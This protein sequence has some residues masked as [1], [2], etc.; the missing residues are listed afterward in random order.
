MRACTAATARPVE[1]RPGSEPVPGYRLVARVIDFHNEPRHQLEGRSGVAIHHRDIKPQN[2][3]L[4]GQGVKVADLGLSCLDQ[5]GGSARSQCGLAFAYAAPETFR[6]RVSTGS[7]QY[8]LAITFC[9]L[10]SGPPPS[11]CPPPS[12]ASAGPGPA[13]H[14]LTGDPPSR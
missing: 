9:Q 11:P 1:D 3:M 8:S 14:V 5:P 10:R 2:V 7:D 6:S 12:H 13:E 4:I